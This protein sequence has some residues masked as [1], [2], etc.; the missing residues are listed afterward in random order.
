MFWRY[1]KYKTILAFKIGSTATKEIPVTS[2]TVDTNP[3]IRILATSTEFNISK[4]STPGKLR[5]TLPCLFECAW[6]RVVLCA[7]FKIR[8][9]LSPATDTFRITNTDRIFYI[10]DYYY[11]G[12]R[13]RGISTERYS[14]YYALRVL[15]KFYSGSYCRCKLYD[16]F[17]YAS[18]APSFRLLPWFSLI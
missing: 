8:T 10:V 1:E 14:S 16:R 5:V 6:F 17:F 2:R 4:R 3:T 11:F 12:G 18:S 13:Y 15:P 7:C 9:D